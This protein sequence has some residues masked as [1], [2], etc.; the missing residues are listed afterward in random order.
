[1]LI[2]QAQASDD[3][4]QLFRDAD[5]RPWTITDIFSHWRAMLLTPM[6]LAIC[7]F[8]LFSGWT[9]KPEPTA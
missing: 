3:L 9:H 2:S 5:T 1:V 6:I 4:Y 8:G 7:W